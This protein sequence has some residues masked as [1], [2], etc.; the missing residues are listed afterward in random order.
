M[1]YVIYEVGDFFEIFDTSDKI[2]VL[3]KDKKD[4]FTFEK[5]IPLRDALEEIKPE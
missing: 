1:R 5:M 4:G 2:T 3:V